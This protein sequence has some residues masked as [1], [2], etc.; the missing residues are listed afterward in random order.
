[1][2]IGIT[3]AKLSSMLKHCMLNSYKNAFYTKI[4]NALYWKVWIAGLFRL[5]A[6]RVTYQLVQLLVSL[7]L[8]SGFL[9]ILEFILPTGFCVEE[10]IVMKK[11]YV[12][13]TSSP[14][15]GVKNSVL[16]QFAIVHLIFPP[17]WLNMHAAYWSMAN[18][19]DSQYI[20]L[21][22]SLLLHNNDLCFLSL[23]L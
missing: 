22:F 4:Y 8:T 9:W 7:N 21:F 20:Q 18:S 3:T 13:G 5:C 1:M 10:E 19:L 16:L 6:N 12:Q 23:A 17:H 15:C 2:Q 14:P 11:K